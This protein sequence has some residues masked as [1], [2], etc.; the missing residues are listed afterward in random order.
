MSLLDD[1]KSGK[2][3][4]NFLNTNNQQVNSETNLEN[5]PEETTP[6][7]SVGFGSNVFRTLV[8]AG[9]DLTQ[10][11]LDFG[12]FITP[13][14]LDYGIIYGDDPKTEEVESGLRFGYTGKDSGVP[15]ATLP[16]VEEPTY[17]GGSF[18]R[19]VAQFAVPFSRLNTVTAPFKTVAGPGTSIGSNIANRFLTP[20]F[21]KN[22][23]DRFGSN[24]ARYGTLGAVTENIAFSPYEPRLSN[25]VQEYPM[26]ENPIT[27]YLQSD[28][29]DSEAEARLKMTIEGF[30]LGIPFEY[31][32]SAINTY[33]RNK[34]IA[35]EQRIAEGIEKNKL[36]EGEDFVGPVRPEKPI[37]TTVDEVIQDQKLDIPIY[38]EDGSLDIDLGKNNSKLANYLKRAEF[39]DD[40]VA[41]NKF[42]KRRVRSESYGYGKK[43]KNLFERYNRLFGEG[44]E[45]RGLANRFLA[46]EI[47]KIKV[48]ADKDWKK[49][50][51]GKTPESPLNNRLQEPDM[52]EV[53][54]TAKGVLRQLRPFT[55]AQLKVSEIGDSLGLNDSRGRPSRAYYKKSKPDYESETQKIVREKKEQDE[56]M[57]A[58]W[59][60]DLAEQ[61]ERQGFELSYDTASQVL[62][63]GDDTNS[64]EN[65]L[66]RLIE[67]DAYRPNDAIKLREY[68]QLRQS[69][70][71]ER[72]FL[73][74]EG[75]DPDELLDSQIDAILLNTQKNLDDRLDLDQ[76]IF[77]NY[78]P[79]NLRGD[80]GLPLG[81]G[82]DVPPG[83]PP[84]PR[85]DEGPI[86][87]GPIDPDKI[88]NIN[89]TKYDLRPEDIE[90]LT[91]QAI[92]NN[93]WVG[94][95]N[96]M[97]FGSDGSILREDALASGLTIDKFVNAPRNYKF[98]PQEIMAARMMLQYLAKQT[99]ELS[100]TLKAKVELGVTP[101][102][103]E[104]YNF[105]LLEMDLGAVGERIVGETAYAGQLLNSF[106]Y[107]VENLTAVQ[108][109]KFVDDIVNAR[110]E[111]KNDILARVM[112]AAELDPDAVAIN[113]QSSVRPPSILDMTQEFWIN[114]LLSGIPTQAVNVGSNALVAGFRP[115][116]SYLASVSGLVGR[117]FGS[118]KP[119][120]SFSESNGRAF[121]TIY[122]L[123]D[124][125]KSFGKAFYDPESVKDP[126]TKLE[127]ARQKAI[128]TPL[129]IPEQVP[130]V[131]GFDLIGDT[132]RLPGR[133]LLAGDT[134]FKQLSYNQEIYGR[135]FD[136]AAKKG[137]R[138]PKDFMTE[139]NNLVL[140]HRNNPTG[141][142]LGDNFEEI[143]REQGRYQT[144]TQDLG[145]SGRAFQKMLNGNMQLAKFIV[146]FVRTPVNIVKFYG[147]RVPLFNAFSRRLRQDFLAG[148]VRRD[149][150]IAKSALGLGLGY[151][152]YELASQGKIIGGGPTDRRERSQWL[153]DNV[154]YSFVGA[155]GKTYEFFRFEPV[156][157]I[158]G[159]NADLHGVIKE[160]SE[161]PDLYGE[162]G[163]LLNDKWGDAILQLT[164]GMLFSLQRNL[165]DKT[166]F[167]GITDFVNALETDN[168]SSMEAYINNFAAS[169]VPTML[170]NIND[171]EDPFIR[172]ARDAMDKIKDDLPFF[173]N[174]YLPK[175]RNIFGEPKLRRKQGSQVFSPITID[176]TPPDPMLEE[177]NNANYYPGQMK[178]N[179][180]GVELNEKQ[181]EYMLSR[182]ENINGR[183]ARELFENLTSRFND[184]VPPR[185]RRDELTKL[186]SKIRT[187]A[188]E[189]TLNALIKDKNSPIYDPVW[190]KKYEDKIKDLQ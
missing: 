82:A 111:E 184:N 97:K 153:Q 14:V 106:K 113:A 155:D 103:Q 131:G 147:E 81:E 152:A 109:R 23:L 53:F 19:D 114:T 137:L 172:D 180:D 101:S 190:A 139:V 95:R 186:M 31:I 2:D 55:Y 157:M 92:R 51:T 39:N 140:Q 56:I 121:A 17:F 77:E 28:P 136:I 107:A 3:F 54:P 151:L 135:A 26:L 171:Y 90:A 167:R 175:K 7:E 100:R 18:L 59:W 160:I 98:S 15:R 63:K 24:I 85:S 29:N 12:K 120:L 49:Y 146:P 177:F 176:S 125:I 128:N 94:A 76:E 145:S 96:K 166:F 75:F 164:S 181:Y 34:A 73:E 183:T 70:D 65:V 36:P 4:T 185:I 66:K 22:T 150:F 93:N 182:L 148:G 124:A 141:K 174:K 154:P 165:T 169:F 52:P 45:E 33:S 130:L 74:G 188:R 10:G 35:R 27:E 32:S 173:S 61:F 21:G 46:E 89:L 105:Q 102:N 133:T 78:T 86:P 119:R 129:K 20:G 132:I 1:F 37:E 159:I 112:N 116:E 11:T 99:S 88:A 43:F 42:I 6:E 47:S 58:Q 149:E 108:A 83:T 50:K 122:G 72:R 9:R 60:D 48:K 30:G 117:A 142:V 67:E 5:L 126:N 79:P 123:R 104:L 156:A 118:K 189:T 178:R 40:D 127:L 110:K 16:E 187:F 179:I 25:L 57:D 38:R 64:A 170:R 115:I 41:F 163:E 87:E 91:S 138:N 68:E 44:N 162:N 71:E 143:A 144:F 62:A 134:F 69:I 158:F 84:P 13:D 161:N 168:A 8:G 80:Q